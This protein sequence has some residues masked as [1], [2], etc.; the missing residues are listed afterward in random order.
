MKHLVCYF[1]S[2][3]FVSELL[4]Q[5]ISLNEL[6]SPKAKVAPSPIWRSSDKKVEVTISGNTF[7][8]KKVTASEIDGELIFEGDIVLKRGTE[9]SDSRPSPDPSSS[10]GASFLAAKSKST[11]NAARGIP[12]GVVIAGQKYRWPS[13]TIPYEIDP[14]LPQQE[15]VFDAIKH[16]E[17]KTPIRLVE[18]TDESNYVYFTPGMGCSSMVGMQGGKQNITLA[19]TQADIDQGGNYGVCRLGHVIHEI[20]H[21]AGLW[22]EQS[23]EDRDQYVKILLDNI[24]PAYR[25]N[26]DQHV[27]DGDDIGE[28]DFQSIMHYPSDAFGKPDENGKKLQTIVV[29]DGDQSIGQ[30]QGLSKNDISTVIEMYN[31]VQ[32]PGE[33][34]PGEDAEQD[35]LVKQAFAKVDKARGYLMSDG[36]KKELKIKAI[37]E[38]Y[39]ALHLLRRP[40]GKLKYEY[41]YLVPSKKPL[42]TKRIAV[43][44]DK[45]KEHRIVLAKES[46]SNIK[47]KL[48][49]KFMLVKNSPVKVH[50]ISIKSLPIYTDKPSVTRKSMTFGAAGKVLAPNQELDT[51]I[52][53]SA[54]VVVTL[55]LSRTSEKLSKL[56]V[57]TRLKV[58]FYGEKIEDMAQNPQR[59]VVALLKRFTKKPDGGILL[60]AL[61]KMRQEKKPNKTQ[62]TVDI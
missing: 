41:A 54:K 38:V 13:G 43:R 20:G 29:L 53:N 10:A 34:P 19:P 55:K 4:A 5:G 25:H 56:P 11:V 14:K 48:N 51:S 1:I 42:K 28:Y 16:W 9:S 12:I 52:L 3:I 7:T 57:A 26:F 39:G 15:R 45:P 37:N 32:P 58:E 60:S 21:A 22:H 23:R 27:T 62:L 6:F 61:E 24:Y 2:V 30:R 8:N 49:K 35:I 46:I 36:D 40:K 44:G 18:R 47:L 33:T 17:S 50:K 31:F 59:D